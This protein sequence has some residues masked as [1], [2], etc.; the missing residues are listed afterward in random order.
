MSTQLQGATSIK[1]PRTTVSTAFSIATVIAHRYKQ[2]RCIPYVAFG[3]ATAV[4]FSRLS[5]SQHFAFDVL[6]GA[7]LGYSITRF[8]VLQY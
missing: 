8:R 7:A 2:R 1:H 5:L 4:G 3:A 6:L